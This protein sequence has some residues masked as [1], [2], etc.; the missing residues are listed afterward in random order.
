MALQRASYRHAIEWIAAN[1]EAA[2]TELGPIS[3]N[4]STAIVA[5]LFGTTTEKVAKAVLRKRRQL[6]P[7]LWEG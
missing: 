3:Q 2:E 7:E 6:F 5:D 4:V 1:D